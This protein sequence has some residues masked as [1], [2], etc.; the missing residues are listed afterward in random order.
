MTKYD[1]VDIW[2]YLNE[3]LVPRQGTYQDP[4]Q[5]LNALFAS[6]KGFSGALGRS[7]GNFIIGDDWSKDNFTISYRDASGQERDLVVPWVATWNSRTAFS[8][9]SGT[10]L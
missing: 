6:T 9:T 5:R 8:Y 3:T 2:Q 4:A 7:S 10:S 1:G